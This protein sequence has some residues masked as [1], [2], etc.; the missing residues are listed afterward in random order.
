M[1]PANTSINKKLSLEELMSVSR[2]ISCLATAEGTKKNYS[3]RIGKYQQFL[4]EKNIHDPILPINS[5]HVQCWLTSIHLSQPELG[6]GSFKQNIAALRDYARI[7]GV[8]DLQ[9]L[10]Y[11][12]R[13]GKTT[14]F[15]IFMQGL[16]RSLPD[17]SEVKQAEAID[18]DLL[19][20]VLLHLHNQIGPEINLTI[21]RDVTVLACM[22]IL[23]LRA[24]DLLMINTDHVKFNSHE[25]S[26]SFV[27]LGG[28]TNKTR[29]NIVHIQNTGHSFNLV[30]VIKQYFQQIDALYELHK[31]TVDDK[32][33]KLFVNIAPVSST[34]KDNRISTQ[35]ITKILRSRLREYLLTKDNLTEAEIENI[36]SNY[37]SHSL[38][39]GAATHAAK[40]GA[41][42]QEIQKRCR[43]TNSSTMK[44]YI[45]E[46]QINDN[47]SNL[48]KL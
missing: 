27:L 36:I 47:I 20:S 12:Q 16:R 14:P 46:S 35:V 23:G 1:Q 24:C 22:F 13:N 45:D 17:M 28:K 38:K 44:R 11:D 40:M 37:S 30:E 39:R 4:T 34:I 6:F 29:A 42:D 26:V 7:N 8:F 31:L 3:S 10:E 41:T 32:G 2:Q 9:C 5:D 43:W 15:S 48:M 19:K 21:L 33:K 18:K 25:D